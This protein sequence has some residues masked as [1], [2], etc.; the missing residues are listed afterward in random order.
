[1]HK[2]SQ[3]FMSDI[4]GKVRGI[5]PEDRL[6]DGSV[7]I[8]VNDNDIKTI[9]GKKVLRSNLKAKLE[10]DLNSAG[11]SAKVCVTD[12]M[13]IFYGW[14]MI[15][16]IFLV[17]VVNLYFVLKFGIRNIGLIVTKWKNHIIG[18]KLETTDDLPS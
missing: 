8:S 16:A 5:K 14:V 11:L 12:E 9:L 1:M 6:E 18:K 17:M 15:G 13:K 10:E 4:V 2:D 7:E 3:K